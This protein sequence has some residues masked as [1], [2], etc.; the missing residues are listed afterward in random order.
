MAE[1]DVPE[2]RPPPEAAAPAHPDGHPAGPP[3]PVVGIGASAGGLEA[4][5]ELLESLSP[6]PGMAFLFV[7]HLDPHHKSHLTEI[8]GK[9][10]SMAVRE[11]AEG[12]AVEANNVYVIPPGT[13]MAITDG[14]LTLTPRSPT[15]GPHMPIDHLFRSL[16][17]PPSWSASP[18]TPTPGRPS[19]RP[20]R[21]R[22][23][24][25]PCRRL[26][27]CCARAPPSISPTTSRRPS[28]GASSA[29]WR[30]AAWR[31]RAT[32]STCCA[33]SRWS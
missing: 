33:T 7:S 26:S 22:P 29:A 13:N 4:F 2:N 6:D 23:R 21:P 3:F 32:T 27:T 28:N 25:T 1:S 19:R 20:S 12:M 11:V 8:F 31:S 17:A 9:V 14:R 15:T 18:A 30:C 10:T 5:T 24:A 16:A